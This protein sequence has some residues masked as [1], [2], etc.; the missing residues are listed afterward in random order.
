MEWLM[1]N[2]NE[3]PYELQNL[4]HHFKHAKEKSWLNLELKCWIEKTGDSFPLPDLAR[5]EKR[6]NE[7]AR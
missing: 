1:F 5:R 4:A 6:V 2:L 3:D 7:T